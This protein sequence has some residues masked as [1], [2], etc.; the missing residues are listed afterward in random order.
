LHKPLLELKTDD[1]EKLLKDEK[2]DC[3]ISKRLIKRVSSKQIVAYK[4]DVENLNK[5]NLEEFKIL[6][7]YYIVR[8][9]IDYISRMTDDFALEE[10]KILLAIK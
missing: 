4:N 7:F 1:F 6:E 9:I 8:L 5:D 10:Y 3:F 2:I